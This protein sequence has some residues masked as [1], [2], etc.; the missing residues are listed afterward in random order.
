MKNKFSGFSREQ[1]FKALEVIEKERLSL[2]ERLY[3]INQEEE[4]LYR[5]LS[6]KLPP[7]IVKLETVNKITKENLLGD[8]VFPI[9]D[10]LSVLF[11]N[12]FTYIIENSTKK[13]IYKSSRILKDFI[14]YGVKYGNDITFKPKVEFRIYNYDRTLEEYILRNPIYNIKFI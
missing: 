6:K 9:D 5:E 13:I 10:E 4:E 11:D 12:C 3:F 1:I 8:N 2:T 7:E 14:E